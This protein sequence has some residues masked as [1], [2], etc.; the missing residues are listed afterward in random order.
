MPS[1]VKVGEP[2]FVEAA[3]TEVNDEHNDG[4]NPTNVAA[5]VVGVAA[6]FGVA[7]VID[8]VDDKHSRSSSKHSVDLNLNVAV[9]E[10]AA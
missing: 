6:V 4:A 7:A 2:E 9:D 10:P 5:A 8:A 1:D 3:C